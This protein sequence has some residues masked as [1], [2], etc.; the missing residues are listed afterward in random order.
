MYYHVHLSSAHCRGYT[1]CTCTFLRV[2]YHENGSG[3]QIPER[4][5]GVRNVSLSSHT[6]LRS[7]SFDSIFVTC[8]VFATHI[9]FFVRAVFAV[10]AM[11]R[12]AP[13][14]IVRLNNG[15]SLYA[16]G[17]F[18]EMSVWCE[19]ETIQLVV[20]L[21]PRPDRGARPSI[22]PPCFAPDD[23]CAQAWP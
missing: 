13:S 22:F 18:R 2:H 9:V 3:Q 4:T 7:S 19:Q 17:L 1:D 12:P 20:N 6:V 5:F 23:C 15:A 21:L 8:A 11:A 16:S 10:S 14:L